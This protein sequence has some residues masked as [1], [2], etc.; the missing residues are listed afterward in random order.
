MY[1]AY[2]V[3]QD[4]LLLTCDKALIDVEAMCDLIYK[5]PWGPKRARRTTRLAIE[6][7]L[8]FALLRGG[9]L[10]G[11]VRVITDYTTIAYLADVV[12]DESLRGQGVGQWMLRAIMESPMLG[13]QHRY[14]LLTEDAQSFYQ[15]L[16]FAPLE[17]PDWAMERVVPYPND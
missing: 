7:S 13:E 5:Q 12:V 16:G 10:V 8:T 3:T 14:L 9:A 11:C 6:N 1:A 17:H 2:S 15:K 4:D